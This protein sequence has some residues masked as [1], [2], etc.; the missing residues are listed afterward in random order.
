MEVEWW[1]ISLCPR[2][3]GLAWRHREYIWA[4]DDLPENDEA[5]ISWEV[6]LGLRLLFLSLMWE[7]RPQTHNHAPRPH[8][9]KMAWFLQVLITLFTNSGFPQEKRSSN[10]CTDYLHSTRYKVYYSQDD[11][12]RYP[13]LPTIKIK[14]CWYAGKVWFLKSPVRHMRHKNIAFHTQKSPLYKENGRSW[15]TI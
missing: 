15:N 8:D 5:I 7:S 14:I 11:L 3:K 13:S 6:I 4:E 10:T 12:A 9:F 2:P 1:L